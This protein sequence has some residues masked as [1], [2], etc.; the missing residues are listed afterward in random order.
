MV[1]PHSMA[2]SLLLRIMVTVICFEAL[3]SK[4]QAFRMDAIGPIEPVERSLPF[5]I[6]MP[7]TNERFTTFYGK[8]LTPESIEGFAPSFKRATFDNWMA[9]GAGSPSNRRLLLRFGK[10]SSPIYNRADRLLRFGKRSVDY[11]I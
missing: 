4:T 8:R 5:F 3:S 2:R 9:S 6:R 1:D 7:I 10:R 11:F